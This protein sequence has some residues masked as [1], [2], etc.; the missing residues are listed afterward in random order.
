MRLAFSTLGVPGMPIDA[1]LKLANANGYDGI[2][3]RAREGEPVTTAL[4]A[5]GR[6]E[7]VEQFAAAGVVPLTVAA[8]TRVAAQGDDQPLL[9]DLRAHVQLAADIGALFVRVFPGGGDLPRPDADDNAARRLGAVAPFA[10]ELGVR[11]LLETHDSHSRAS[12]AAAVL[13]RVG[14]EGAGIIWDLMHT[15]RSGE[16]PSESFEACAPYLGYVQVKDIAGHEDTTPLALGD[17]LLPIGECVD[18][19]ASGGYQGWLCW[20]YEAAW[21]PDAAPYPPLLGEAARFLRAL[22]GVCGGGGESGW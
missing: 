13:A 14:F 17:G 18:A 9:D 15:W 3:L 7:V 8:Y 21:Y 6:R 22:P 5:D 12:D 11:V 4:G 2:E 19:L 10:A 20:E 16:Q 1:V